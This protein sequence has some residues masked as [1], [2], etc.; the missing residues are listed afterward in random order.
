MS[1]IRVYNKNIDLTDR[2]SLSQL[3]IE[4]LIMYARIKRKKFSFK[5]CLIEYILKINA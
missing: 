4:Q 5:E 3:T 2:G 1:T